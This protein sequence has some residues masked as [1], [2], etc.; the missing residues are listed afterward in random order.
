MAWREWVIEIIEWGSKKFR[1]LKWGCHESLKG[2]AG[3]Y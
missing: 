3:G 2:V 1:V